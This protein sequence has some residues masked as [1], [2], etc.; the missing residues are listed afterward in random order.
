MKNKR[1]SARLSNAPSKRSSTG[2]STS[3]EA[4]ESAPVS[5]VPQRLSISGR[6][7]QA[8]VERE[9]GVEKRGEAKPVMKLKL[10]LASIPTNYIDSIQVSSSDGNKSLSPVVLSREKTESEPCKAGRTSC[11][12]S[13]RNA[14]TKRKV[15]RPTKAEALARSLAKAK[16]EGRGDI[17]TTLRINLKRKEESPALSAAATALKT[18][19]TSTTRTSFKAHKATGTIVSSREAQVPQ[20]DTRG[21]GCH[22]CQKTRRRPSRHHPTKTWQ[23][24]KGG[25]ETS[26]PG[27]RTKATHTT[28]IRCNARLGGPRLGC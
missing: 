7:S 15:G 24:D 16:A 12:Y 20:E 28:H 1:H 22:T 25:S 13:P 2:K 17:G 9:S 5:P 4:V 19:P 3:V 6:R 27:A 26:S 8:P 14:A 23:T 11:I 10:N 18:P 21:E